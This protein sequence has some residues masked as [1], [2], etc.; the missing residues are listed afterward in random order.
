MLIRCIVLALLTIGAVGDT[1]VLCPQW[2]CWHPPQPIDVP[3]EPE[4]EREG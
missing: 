3:Q 1:G 4:A 2:K